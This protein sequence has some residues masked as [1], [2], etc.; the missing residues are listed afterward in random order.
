MVTEKAKK[1][2]A[3]FF[4]L[5]FKPKSLPRDFKNSL[6]KLKANIILVLN[7]NNYILDLFARKEF[8][9]N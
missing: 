9:K 8:V 3:Y 5:L 6:R 2:F 7:K 1:Y 4:N